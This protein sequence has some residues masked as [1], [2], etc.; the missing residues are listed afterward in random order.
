VNAIEA[1]FAAARESAPVFEERLTVAGRPLSLQFSGAVVRDA[2][3]PAFAHLPAPGPGEAPELT[4][5]ALDGESVDLPAVPWD[6]RDVREL[7]RVRGFDAGEVRALVDWKSGAVTVADLRRK[8]AFFLVSDAS[9][10]PWFESAAP[11]RAALHWL[12]GAAG[13]GLVHAGAVG[14]GGE[15]VLIAGR[16]GNGK[17]TLAVAAV[18]AGLDFAGDDYIALGFEPDPVAHS[19]HATA[20]LGAASMELLPKA[21]P[22]VVR[23]TAGPEEKTSLDLSLLRDGCVVPRLRLRGIVLPRLSTGSPDLREV[24]GAEALLALAPST[25]FQLPGREGDAMD[26]LAELARQVPAWE[27]STGDGPHAAAA[28]LEGLVERVR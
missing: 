5:C 1:A 16:G 4:I 24:S 26:G 3:L 17:S 22:A 27:L 25:V 20:K 19:I 6:A 13:A 21:R 12:L 28:T 7:G 2:L 14:S 18:L 8:R 15:G 11:F 23:A 9:R 10:M